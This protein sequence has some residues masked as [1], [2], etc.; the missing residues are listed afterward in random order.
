MSD[1]VLQR[2]KLDDDDSSGGQNRDCSLQK[3]TAQAVIASV[4]KAH[5]K[6][7]WVSPVVIIVRQIKPL[8]GRCFRDMRVHVPT[9]IGVDWGCLQS[10]PACCSQ[11]DFASSV[12]CVPDCHFYTN[13]SYHHVNSI[14]IRVLHQPSRGSL[15]KCPHF[16]FTI[17]LE[18]CSFYVLINGVSNSFENRDH[19]VHGRP[20]LS[21][22]GQAFKSKGSDF[23]HP[24]C[25]V[26]TS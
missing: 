7:H 2:W 19:L 17:G 23:L 4:C 6:H 15:P 18:M 9:H 8:V 5:S 1:F 13:G 14:V 21:I 11:S 26:F 12:A 24:A 20:H 25:G 22:Q 10:P 16:P 3:L